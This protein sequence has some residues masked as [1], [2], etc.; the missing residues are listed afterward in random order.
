MRARP[1]LAQRFARLDVRAEERVDR[2]QAGSGVP[3]AS[4]VSAHMRAAVAGSLAEA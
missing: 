3:S 1:H 2:G 4:S